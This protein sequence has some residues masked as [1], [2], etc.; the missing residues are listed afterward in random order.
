L[1]LEPS[2]LNSANSGKIR[3]AHVITRLH[4]A[5]G[6]K[7]TLLTCAGLDPSR[8]EVD[9]IVGASADRWRADGIPVN[10]VQIPAMR[11]SIHPLYDAR[12]G[13]DLLALFRKRRY[14]IVH[15]HLAKAGIVGRWA[16]HQAQTPLVIHGLHGATFNPTQSKVENAVYLWL[17][18]KAM[19]AH[20]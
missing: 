7:N 9:L 12:A 17:E 15:T 11:R 4:G 2:T 10:W 5:G 16:A 13:L 18:K 1:N 20:S 19:T 3:V 8:Y 6:A 14:H